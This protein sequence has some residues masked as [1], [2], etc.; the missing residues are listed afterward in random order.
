MKHTLVATQKFV[1]AGPGGSI[2]IDASGITL[3]AFTV[4]VQSPSVDFNIGVPNVAEVLAAA[5]AL[6]MDTNVMM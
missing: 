2:E 3:K 1:I 4:K 5:Q 6:A